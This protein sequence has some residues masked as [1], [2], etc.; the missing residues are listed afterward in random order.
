MEFEVIKVIDLNDSTFQVEI[1]LED[2]LRRNFCYPKGEGW[3]EEFNGQYRFIS[4]ITQRLGQEEKIKQESLFN[5]DNITKKLS[6]KKINYI[7]KEKK[8][9][10]IKK[11]TSSKC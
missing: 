1:E 10:T 6:N 4:N 3:E 8:T 2:R 5:A 9:K 7:T 11:I